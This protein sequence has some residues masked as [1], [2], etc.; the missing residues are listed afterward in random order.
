MTGLENRH[1]LRSRFR[2]RGEPVDRRDARLVQAVLQ[3]GFGG[4]G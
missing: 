4:E 1:R 2:E 3:D